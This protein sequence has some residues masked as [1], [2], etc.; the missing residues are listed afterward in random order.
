[1]VKVTIEHDGDVV[2][3]QECSL[4]VVS[5]QSL[6]DDPEANLLNVVGYGPSRIIAYMKLVAHIVRSI[7]TEIEDPEMQA[8]ALHG[9]LEAVKE[10]VRESIQAAD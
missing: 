8:L 1:M 9:L 2:C 3:S 10:G 7:V 5:L 4:A 6:K